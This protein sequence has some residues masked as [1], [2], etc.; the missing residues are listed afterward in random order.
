MDVSH[1]VVTSSSLLPHPRG[2]RLPGPSWSPQLTPGISY[3]APLTPHR[4]MRLSSGPQ[5]KHAP[6]RQCS[7]TGPSL[8]GF[9]PPPGSGTP[10]VL[11]TVPGI[12]SS[13]DGSRIAGC[14]QAAVKL[15]LVLCSLLFVS[16]CTGYLTGTSLYSSRAWGSR[17][18]DCTQG[19]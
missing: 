14:W 8:L 2:R 9:C 5:L 11:E 3:A 1:I 15:C 10:G 6:S 16:Y 13:W 7:S 18:P 4:S 17:L 12:N 19:N